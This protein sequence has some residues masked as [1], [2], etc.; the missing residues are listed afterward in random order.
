MSNVKDSIRVKSE[1]Y[2]KLVN[3]FNGIISENDIIPRN[4]KI[5]LQELNDGYVIDTGVLTEAFIGA[6]KKICLPNSFNKIPVVY[7][8]ENFPFPI[9]LLNDEQELD[10]ETH[11]IVRQR[12]ENGYITFPVIILSD[13]FFRLTYGEK[14]SY[15]DIINTLEDSTREKAMVFQK[16]EFKY[17]EDYIIILRHIIGIYYYKKSISEFRL[18][19]EEEVEEYN[20]ELETMSG[21][22]GL[23]V[24]QHILAIFQL[25]EELKTLEKN[26]E[27]HTLEWMAEIEDIRDK[28]DREVLYKVTNTPTEKIS[29]FVLNIEMK[30]GVLK[31][32]VKEFLSNKLIK[33]DYDF[34]EKDL[35]DLVS[36][37]ESL[38][39]SNKAKLS[40]IGTFSS[41]K[42]TLINTFLGDR[43]VPLRTSMGHNTAVLMH[44]YYEKT[45]KE[46]YDIVYKDKLVWSI[47]K[48]VSMEKAVVN[49]EKD[50]ITILNIKQDRNGNY[51]VSYSISKKI[52]KHTRRIRTKSGLAV[53]KGDIVKP[54]APLTVASKKISSMVEISSKSEIKLILSLLDKSKNNKI[55]LVDD[56]IHEKK[57]I[58]SLLGRIYQIASEKASTVRYESL[59]DKIDGVTPQ[60]T[61]ILMRKN[62]PS[63]SPKYR[64]IEF[65]C[66]ID[67]PNE[68]KDL[69]KK[70]WID[71]CG[72]PNPKSKDNNFV[73]SETPSCYMLAKELQL[74]VNSEFLQYCSLMD[75]PGF[76]SV[77]D[78]HDAITE[79]YIRDCSGR[80]LVMIAINAKTIDAKYTDLINSIEDIY[81]NFRKLDKGNVVFILNCFTN[82]T[83]EGNI[84]KQVANVY[85]MLISYGFKKQNFYVCDLK[86]AL[87][88]KQQMETMYGYPSYKKF[89]DYILSE[90][91]SADL[92]LKYKA[93]KENWTEFFNESRD[94][95]N[96][97]IYEK[98]KNINDSDEYKSRIQNI[99]TEIKNIEIID[100]Y[101]DRNSLNLNDEFNDMYDLLYDAYVNNKKGIFK[102]VRLKEMENAYKKIIET[103]SGCEDN[104]WIGIDRDVIDNIKDYYENKIKLIKYYAESQI[105]PPRLE[106]DLQSSIVVLEIEQLENIITEA[107]AETHWYNKHKK[108]DYYTTKFRDIID[109][110]YEQTIEKA[111]LLC[112]KYYAQVCSYRDS[113]L[114]EKESA[115]KGLDNKEETLAHLEKLN[116]V[117]RNITDLQKEF[118][119]IDFS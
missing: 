86:R 33:E 30:Y 5:T 119:K 47:V 100:N 60:S 19:L 51:L 76:G 36:E 10:S 115:L 116:I 59:C 56:T 1:T 15:N 97:Q 71:L 43:E 20:T 95:V 74:H 49:K 111:N 117:Q 113:I 61:N 89:Q 73:F 17:L 9:I 55:K 42:T 53:S 2:E 108:K 18:M 77:T 85:Q 104:D 46:Y 94:R 106:E 13:D 82:L 67:K 16:D 23:I 11:K 24:C 35:K 12:Y 101:E 28:Y 32:N 91:I 84:K 21:I 87:V 37:T 58:I 107:D 62:V 34:V 7:S 88:D 93:I 63:Y 109:K 70:G 118:N 6:N 92:S 39:S 27:K 75:T 69:D 90:M 105:S 31:N 25:D 98:E 29:P 3:K 114:R 96:K 26:F 72:D 8:I 68:R 44:L 54:G 14:F 22:G 52:G 81:S 112:R 83:P 50:S 110:G 40:L 80:L 65:E 79:R 41:G 64:R 38:I 99:I 66:E 57:R 103:I 102:T 45:N 48:P 78:E 4:F